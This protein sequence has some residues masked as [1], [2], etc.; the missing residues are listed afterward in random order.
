MGKRLTIA[1]AMLASLPILYVGSYLVLV[2]AERPFSVIN[3]PGR[4]PRLVGYR[5]GGT[6]AEHVFA[7]IHAVDKQLRKDYW[8]YGLGDDLP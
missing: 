7:P 4:L 1:L 6:I 8:T 2:Q 3:G 5:I